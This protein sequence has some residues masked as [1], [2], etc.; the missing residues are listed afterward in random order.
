VHGTEVQ[1]EWADVPIRSILGGG[2]P[3][4]YDEEADQLAVSQRRGEWCFGATKFTRMDAR[5]IASPEASPSESAA[6]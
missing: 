6:P 1:V 2:P 5:G 3:L 4:T